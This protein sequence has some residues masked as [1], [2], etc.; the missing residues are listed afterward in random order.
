MSATNYMLLSAGTPSDLVA[1]VNKNREYVPYGGLLQ[2]GDKYMQLVVKIEAAPSVA[3]VQMLAIA[4]KMPNQVK[5]FTKN[6]TDSMNIEYKIVPTSEINNQGRNGFFKYGPAVAENKH[7]VVKLPR[8]NSDLLLQIM[9]SGLSAMLLGKTYAIRGS[10]TIEA[11][12]VL[13]GYPLLHAETLLQAVVTSAPNTEFARK[14]LGYLVV[15][16]HERED[17]ASADQ[18]A[19]AV[20]DEAQQHEAAGPTVDQEEDEEG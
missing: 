7:V 16:H 20:V 18:E 15:E 5:N 9:C 13:L 12:D 1:Q 17:A 11:D 3:W 10:E 6:K 19:H 2:A 4:T 14:L 8:R